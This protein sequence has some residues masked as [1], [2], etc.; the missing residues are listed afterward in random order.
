M[1]SETD[2]KFLKITNDN[3]TYEG[4]VLN[5]EPHGKGFFKYSDKSEC[6]GECFFGKMD[7]YGVFYQN[8]SESIYPRYIGY[9]NHGYFNGVG[10]YETEQTICKGTW[11]NGKKHGFF[12]KTN[13][14]EELSYRQ[15]W[16]KNKIKWSIKIDYTH[17]DKLI[18]TKIATKK[19][20]K[21][22]YTGAAKKCI[23]CYENNANA[24][25]IKCGHVSMCYECLSQCKNCP[26]CRVT[27]DQIIKLYLS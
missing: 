17:P 20:E 3:Y 8:K 7:G 4:T 18:T 1:T 14:S 15:L 9:F 12:I 11:R 5:D 6:A 21:K 23:A 19:K 13:K 22:E 16:I 10:T 2:S 25:V 26:I 27:I 24:T